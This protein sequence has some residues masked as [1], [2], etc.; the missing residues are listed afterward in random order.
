MNIGNQIIDWLYDDELQ[1]DD[2]W[3]VR[4]D[5]G[6]TWWADQYAQTIEILDE[7]AGPEGLV[8]YLIGV[9]TEMVTELDL[10]DAA[11][12]E[13]NDGP[14]RFAS[15]SG[16]VYDP[17]TRTLSLCSLGRVHDQIAG[18][19]G[20]LLGSAAATQLAEARMLAPSLADLIGGRAAVSGHPQNGVRPEPDEMAF[21]AQ[22]FVEGG[23]EPCQWPEA[24][25]D[26]AVTQFMRKPPSLGAT[27]GGQG[28]TVEFPY[29]QKSSLCQV[30]GTQ[31][32]P[33]YGNGLLVLQRFPFP[34]ESEAKGA[35]LAMTLNAAELTQNATGFG[36]G[37]YVYDNGMVCFTGFFPNSLHRQVAL[38]NVYFSCAGRAHAMSVWLLNEEWTADSFSADHSAIVRNTMSDNENDQDSP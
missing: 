9:R 36:F 12:T 32:H 6:F 18:W 16:P 22:M 19:M 13:L 11:L 20:V 8:G 28:F 25:F 23:R 5:K 34:V 14:M 33:L 29:G 3:A 17:E 37:S 38:P 26:A 27:S 31:P 30:I 10:T 7:E 1:I 24:D 35:T 2:E 15:M 21:A 4:T